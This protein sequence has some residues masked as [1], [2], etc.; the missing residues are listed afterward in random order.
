MKTYPIQEH[1]HTINNVPGRM[2]TIHEPQ[3]VRGNM[4]HRNQTWKSEARPVKGYGPGGEM[5]VTIQFDDQCQNG[6]QTFSITADVVTPASRRRNDIEVGGCLH[7][8]I[9]RVFPELAPLL[10]WHLVS[11]DG[12]M[13]YIANT[14]YHA[15][16]RN[17]DAARHTAC[18]PEA[19]DEELSVDKEPLTAA[20]TA[21]LPGVL[22]AFRA[23]MERIGF[24]WEPGKEEA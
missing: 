8:D 11:T 16:D 14:V 5:R 12:P 20:L 17:L 7:D 22:A 3:S 15:G 4:V 21:R 9:A 18:W 6:H 23:E 2:F 24:M 1:A 10:R 13:H 19:T